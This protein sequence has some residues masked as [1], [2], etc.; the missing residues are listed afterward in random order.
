MEE[1]LLKN[2]AKEIELKYNCCVLQ[3]RY[4]Q[5]LSL[6]VDVKIRFDEDFV[7]KPFEDMPVPY[8]ICFSERT[9]SFYKIRP[10]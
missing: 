10:F 2:I 4:A 3:I 8:T 1:A 5:L 7:Y 6:C 9:V